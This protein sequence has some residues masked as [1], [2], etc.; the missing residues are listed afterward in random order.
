MFMWT[1]GPISEM[2]E[3]QNLRQDAG[4]DYILLLPTARSRKLR[5]SRGSLMVNVVPTPAKLS[6]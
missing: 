6:H 1:Y 4:M 3:M 2:E 5:Y